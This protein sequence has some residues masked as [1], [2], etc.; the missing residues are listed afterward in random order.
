MTKLTPYTDNEPFLDECIHDEKEKNVIAFMFGRKVPSCCSNQ[1]QSPASGSG[2]G[3]RDASGSGLPGVGRPQYGETLNKLQI[4][5]EERRRGLAEAGFKTDRTPSSAV[6]AFDVKSAQGDSKPTNIWA[7]YQMLA[8]TGSLP[9]KAYVELFLLRG[10]V[11]SDKIRRAENRGDR[12]FVI[13]Y[14][15]EI[16][17]SEDY[18]L[19]IDPDSQSA[20][21]YELTK[22]RFMAIVHIHNQRM[23][24]GVRSALTT[25]IDWSNCPTEVANF[26]AQLLGAG[27]QFIGQYLRDAVLSGTDGPTRSRYMFFY[28]ALCGA[29]DYMSYT[30]QLAKSKDANKAL[31]FQQKYDL[32]DWLART[33]GEASTE[34]AHFVLDAATRNLQVVESFSDVEAVTPEG[35]YEIMTWIKILKSASTGMRR[36]AM[37]KKVSDAQ[38]VRDRMRKQA[39]LDEIRARH[40]GGVDIAEC[41]V[42]I[43][44]FVR[45]ISTDSIT[46][47]PP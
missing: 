9:N 44:R 3:G 6:G 22:P 5:E 29:L 7:I 30:G 27:F 10:A 1:G 14:T 34:D 46:V 39:R 13:K 38:A 19:N 47:E 43:I 2:V 31:E 41:V 33:T 21:Q 8:G 28:T 4:S 25:R 18:T 20:G 15:N 36:Q 11:I 17:V 26:Y 35:A 45:A 23:E 32:I 37:T 42:Q 16:G 40:A 24:Y 12:R